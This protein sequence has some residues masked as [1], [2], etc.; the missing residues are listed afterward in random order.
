VLDEPLAVLIARMGLAGQ[1]HLKRPPLGDCPEALDVGEEQID[2]F[3][4]RHTAG[5][6]ED[7]HVRIKIRRTP[8]RA[9]DLPQRRGIDEI[10]N[11]ARNMD[12][13]QL[14][15]V[16][17]NGGVV[18]IVAFASYVKV[19]PPEKVAAIDTLRRSMN[20]TGGGRGALAALTEAQRV[21]YQQKLAVIDAKW[22][23]ANIVDFVNHIDHAV[24]VAGID[25]VGISS[26]F[27]GGGGVTGWRDAAETHNVT[28]ELLRRGYT[29]AQVTKMWSG[30]LLRVW[31]EV[32][33][34]AREIQQGK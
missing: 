30:N 28:V 10:A 4:G 9:G 26:D 34:V 20:I 13:E 1:H 33:R 6:P 7:R 19:N 31:S 14:L 5:E 12:D 11:H 8:L 21:E 17:K 23:P 18:Q 25:H 29:E 3:I 24:K 32:E 22:P 2:T 16:K 15:A 27:D